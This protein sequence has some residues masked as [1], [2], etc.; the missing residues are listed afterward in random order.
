[1]PVGV[2]AGA[3]DAGD[4]LAA[5][6]EF[7]VQVTSLVLGGLVFLDRIRFAFAHASCRMP[8]TCQETFCPLVPPAIGNCPPLTSA[9]MCR[10][11][12]GAPIGVSW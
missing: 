3:G 9:A 8:V 6:V 11:G 7:G 4:R 10:S 1:M 12:A 5:V 2:R